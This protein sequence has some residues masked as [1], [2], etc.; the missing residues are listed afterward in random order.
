MHNTG[1]TPSATPPWRFSD[2]S[3]E[4]VPDSLWFASDFL[5]GAGTVIIQPATLKVVLV[6]RDDMKIWFLPKV[7]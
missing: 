3:T 5:L 6:Y 1:L 4:S 2:N 7:G